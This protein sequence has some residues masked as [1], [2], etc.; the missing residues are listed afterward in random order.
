MKTYT[1]THYVIALTSDLSPCGYFYFKTAGRE[2]KGKVMVDATVDDPESAQ[3][4]YALDDAAQRLF[5][6][7][8]TGWII[9]AM[10]SHEIVD[11]K[12]YDIIK[13]EN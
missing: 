4:Y 5:K 8:G 2:Y 3:I 11:L 9:I 13:K 7:W 10:P 1:I 12:L 6:L